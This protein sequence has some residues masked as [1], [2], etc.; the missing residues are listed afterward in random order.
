MAHKIVWKVGIMLIWLGVMLTGCTKNDAEEIAFEI[1]SSDTSYDIYALHI[2]EDG[3]FLGCGGYAWSTGVIASGATNTNALMTTKIA[4]KG[5]FCIVNDMHRN[6]KIIAG[7][8][9]YVFLKEEAWSFVRLPKWEFIRAAE[10][11]EKKIVFA[12]GGN[13]GYGFIQTYS[14]NFEFQG[15]Y[16]TDREMRDIIKKTDGGFLACGYGIVL[17]SD[18]NAL[19]WKYVQGVSGDFF[20]SITYDQNDTAWMLGQRGNIWK[21]EDNGLT[22]VRQSSHNLRRVESF[23]KII[24]TP[25]G[26]IIIGNGGLLWMKGFNDSDWSKFC[27]EEEIDL[28]DVQFL[29]EHLYIS[30]SLGR[31]YMVSI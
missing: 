28:Y 1:L 5:L 30:G 20:Q 8:D 26:L 24:D 21:S 31:I 4:D 19:D 25:K 17:R 15:F 23:N 22:W 14:E 12:G 2:D 16:E 3:G 29:D 11:S 13:Q 7:V 27:L 10:V 18:E 6:R 9:G